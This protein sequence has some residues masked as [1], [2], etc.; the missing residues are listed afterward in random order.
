MVASTLSNLHSIPT[1]TPM[2]EKAGWTADGH[3]IADN[4]LLNFGSENLWEKWMRDHKFNQAADGGINWVVP[5]YPKGG[6]DPVWSASY[7]LV[8]YV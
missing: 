1:D 2:W 8:N 6:V 4:A 3:L 7:I 5:G